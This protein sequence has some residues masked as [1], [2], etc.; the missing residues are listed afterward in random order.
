MRILITGGS[1]FLGSS[2]T[3]HGVDASRHPRAISCAL[4]F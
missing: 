1:G 4:T 3:P 2:L